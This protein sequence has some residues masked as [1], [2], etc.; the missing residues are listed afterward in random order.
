MDTR[1]PAG[2]QFAHLSDEELR[3]AAANPSIPAKLLPALKAELRGRQAGDSQKQQPWQHAPTPAAV[4]LP[5]ELRVVVTDIHMSFGSMVVFMVKW[6]LASIPAILIL[7][8][9]Y[10]LG[11]G[12]VVGIFGGR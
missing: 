7:L 12:L 10:F 6:T 9:L 11:L 1:D 3:A 8:L 5:N 2:M 4:R